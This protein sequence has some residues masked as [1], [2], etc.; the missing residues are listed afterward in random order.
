[1]GRIWSVCAAKLSKQDYSIRIGASTIQPST[2]VHDLGVHLDSELSMKQH[3][4]NVAASCFY[5][6]YRLRQI[7]RSV[8]S[9]AATRLVLALTMSRLDYCNSV[10]AGLTQIR[11]TPLQRV[12]KAAA[13]L[14]FRVRYRR[15][16]HGERSSTALAVSPLAGPVQAVLFHAVSLLSKFPSYVSNSVRPVDCGRPRCGL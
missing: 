13:R 14:I 11:V 1:M 2:V 5:H 15:P 16:C 9:D 3:V 12:Q 10:L 7:R 8:N 4:A 6:L